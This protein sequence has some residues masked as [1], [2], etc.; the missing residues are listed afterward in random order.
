MIGAAEQDIIDF[1]ARWRSQD[2]QS[3]IGDCFGCEHVDFSSRFGELVLA[4]REIFIEKGSVNK[5]GRETR[6]TCVVSGSL[7]FGA[8]RFLD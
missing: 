5:A 3:S 1:H 2:V 7:K 4:P 8:K 6:D